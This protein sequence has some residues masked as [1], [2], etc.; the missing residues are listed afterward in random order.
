V[1]CPFGSV[2]A[3]KVSTDNARSNYVRARLA[4]HVR[5]QSHLVPENVDKRERLFPA[6]E[7]VNATEVV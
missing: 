4:V 5:I 1:S 3:E 6:F 2:G 7:N